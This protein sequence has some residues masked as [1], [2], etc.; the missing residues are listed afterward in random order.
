MK[1]LLLLHGAIGSSV[2]LESL[3]GLL[4]KEYNVILLNFS[5]HGGREI[6]DEPFSIEMFAEDV[7]SLIDKCRI[8]NPDV[9]GYSMG[10]YVALYI[11]RHFPEKLNRIFT[12]ATKFDW[13]PESS[14]KESK[15]LNPEKLPEK[16]PDFAEELSG[17][18]S[19]ADWKMVLQKTAEMM[20]SLGNGNNLSKEDLSNI[21]NEVRISVGDRDKMVSI[22]ESLDAYRNIENGSFL[23]M[24]YTP[25]PIEKVS[26]ER[27]SGEISLF[28]SD[29]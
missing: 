20:V 4:K 6:P 26:V 28:F 7:I 3:A 16:L 29:K 22:E 15:M 19:P 5:G 10:G 18:H 12:L 13:N 2:Q 24:P 27:L 25:H 1:D 11:A 14:L 21:K 9:F 8:D 23:V 17:R